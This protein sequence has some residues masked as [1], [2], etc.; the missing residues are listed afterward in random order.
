VLDGEEEDLLSLRILDLLHRT[1]PLLVQFLGLDGLGDMHEV[2]FLLLLALRVE[3]L[4]LES[5]RTQS[6]VLV[7]VLLGLLL[8][9]TASHVII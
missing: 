8:R 2:G 4:G 5:H 7:L 3:G 9:R 1:H 6:L